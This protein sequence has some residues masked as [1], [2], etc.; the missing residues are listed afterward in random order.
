MKLIIAIILIAF[1]GQ[2]IAFPHSFQK[3]IV[4]NKTYFIDDEYTHSCSKIQVNYYPHKINSNCTFT[5]NGVVNGELAWKICK[6]H[7]I[8]CAIDLDAPGKNNLF[9]Y[10]IVSTCD[11][12]IKYWLD[13]C[14]SKIDME[15]DKEEMREYIESWKPIVNFVFDKI[16]FFIQFISLSIVGYLAYSQ[17]WIKIEL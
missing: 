17:N 2:T 6:D 5:L 11:A 14:H 7:N 12:N 4:S 9:Q 1:I 15:K 10:T 3:S 13:Q 8:G 16:I